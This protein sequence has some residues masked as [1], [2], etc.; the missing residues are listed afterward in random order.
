MT[1]REIS[2]KALT[3]T[4]NEERVKQMRKHQSWQNVPLETRNRFAQLQN[5]ADEVLDED[6]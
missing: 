6:R 5:T 2:I 4:L 3:E 1:E